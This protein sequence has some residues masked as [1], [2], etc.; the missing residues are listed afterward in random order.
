M[1]TDTAKGA[2]F[3]IPMSNKNSIGRA[4][5]AKQPRDPKARAKLMPNCLLCTGGFFNVHA[6]RVSWCYHRPDAQ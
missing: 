2:L 5:L 3:L 1:A 6:D 4:K